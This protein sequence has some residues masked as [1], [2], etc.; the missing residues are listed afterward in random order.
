M[1][2]SITVGNKKITD[3]VIGVAS[4]D[5]IG[6]EVSDN[7]LSLGL[8][9]NNSV[10]DKYREY[11]EYINT[12]G[13]PFVTSVSG[14][15]CNDLGNLWLLGDKT[16]Q[17]DLTDAGFTLCD[18]SQTVD[19]PRIYK[20]VYAMLRQIRLWL[21]A[22]KDTLLLK[23][24]KAELQWDDMMLDADDW[25]LPS[26]SPDTRPVFL[27]T[28]KR[29]DISA[30]G[31]GLNL[32]NEYRG[33]VS[34]WNYIVEMPTSDIS[35]RLHPADRSGV[36]IGANLTVPV[37]SKEDTTITIR[38]LI[39]I[40]GQPSEGLQ[41]MYLWMRC[42]V[43]RSTPSSSGVTVT[44]PGEPAKSSVDSVLD[45]DSKQVIITPE[46]SIPLEVSMHIPKDELRTSYI[47][48]VVFEAIPFVLCSDKENTYADSKKS[49][50]VDT[51]GENKWTITTEVYRNGDLIR[52]ITET[53]NTSMVPTCDVDDSSES[54]AV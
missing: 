6:V 29:S 28:R 52:T 13:L 45:N 7:T 33:T 30:I 53:K 34:L 48:Q 21:D 26:D 32:L 1:I 50:R 51:T 27:E 40:A 8:K 3:A 35:I 39:D 20:S 23:S 22:H 4:E 42:P 54:E 38:V 41:D 44:I 46:S 18:M 11:L 17:V 12:N 31:P 49:Y 47:V 15:G 5:S 19:Y 9:D 2:T 43:A 10:T 14:V 25:L 16:S 37:T 36:Y 24:D